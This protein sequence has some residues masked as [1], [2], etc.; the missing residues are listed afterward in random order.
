MS[1]GAI[2]A[3]HEAYFKKHPADAVKLFEKLEY[4]EMFRYFDNISDQAVITLM[5]QMPHDSLAVFILRWSNDRKIDILN[6]INAEKLAMVF[7]Q[8]DLSDQ[9]QYFQ[10]LN[11]KLSEEIKDINSYPVDTAGH[12]M[13]RKVITFHD[14]STV[15]A[16][17][18]LIKHFN[19]RGIRVLYL[20]NAHGLL[21]KMVPVQYLLLENEDR[22]LNE[23]ARKIPERVKD[24]DT[25]DEVLSL[26]E[27][28]KMTDLPVVNVHGA[29][30]GI[31]RQHALMKAS[32]EELT[33][34]MQT[35]VG[36]SKDERALSKVTFA[37]KKR[38]PWLQIN[39]LTAFLA[40][41]VVGL[42]ETTIAQFTALAVMLPIV[43]GQSGNTGAQALAV[44]MR[45]LTLKEV[46][47]SHWFTLIFKEAKIATITGISVALTTALCI[48]LW[49]R[50]VGLSLIIGISMVISMVLSGM[51]GAMVPI[52]FTKLK[53]DPAQCS[54]IVLTTIT[55]VVGFSSFLMIATGLSHL[56]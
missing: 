32:K 54:S 49:S 22:I 8:W 7:S 24:T 42:F 11:P 30:I 40:S 18:L 33:S 35:M 4:E 10:W 28:T 25:I 46:R 21:T 31:I 41:A 12:I 48:Y 37:V 38:L 56:I 17:L 47:L 53:M 43:A 6:K 55:D 3:L 13:D 14:E 52:I 45:G 23:I 29:L 50:S 16:A 19:K 1:T 20:V 27:T 26:F 5:K 39:L 9:Q 34:D 51:S 15:K 44:T 36:V 2:L